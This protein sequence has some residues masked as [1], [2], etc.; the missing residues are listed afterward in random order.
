MT[1]QTYDFTFGNRARQPRGRPP[2]VTPEMARRFTLSLTFSSSLT[3]EG[4]CN[5][6]VSE[7][8]LPLPA[9]D[10]ADYA[11]ARRRL[12][13]D[14][15]YRRHARD[16]REYHTRYVAPERVQGALRWGITR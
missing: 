2:R 1:T 10:R 11:R 13:D 15:V 3:G 9:H 6:L 5:T 8:V 12:E 4:D 14:P 16:W 7:T